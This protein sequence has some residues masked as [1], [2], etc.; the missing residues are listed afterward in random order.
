MT[1]RLAALAVA[2]CFHWATQPAI[3]DPAVASTYR[4]FATVEEGERVVA[5]TPIRDNAPPL[6]ARDVSRKT[7]SWSAGSEAGKPCFDPPIPFVLPPEDPAEPFHKHNHQ[8]SI[9]WLPNGDLL[10]I[11][12]STVSEAGTELTV[13]ASRLRH[14][15]KTWDPSSEF[16]KAPNHNMHGSSIFY[17]GNRTLYHFNGM[18]PEGG[19]GWTHLALLMRYSEDWGVTWT[20]PM[21]IG[22]AFKG[23]QQVISG[24]IATRRGVLIQPCDAGTGG[25]GGTALHLSADSGKTW[26]EPGADKPAVQFTMDG[27]GEGTI[28]GIHAGVVELEDGRLMALGRGD[29]IEGR[30]PISL[31][32][33][34]GSTWVYRAS[35]FAPIGMGQR[36]VLRRLQEGPILLVSFTS[37]DRKNPEGNGMPFVGPDGKE[38]IGHGMFAALSFDEGKTWPLRKLLTP[39][40]GKYHGGAWTGAFNATP[41]R[42]EHAGYLAATQSPDG[43]IHLISSRLYYR[44]NLAWL[45]L[46]TPQ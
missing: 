23:R 40:T 3:A 28:A 32:S 6:W 22:P 17:D 26:L 31:S 29:N 44:F 4:H 38:F 9:T 41:V 12:Y 36:L 20:P 24:T 2:T 33:D 39:G 16:F 19:K 7:V 18:G 25:K 43:M 1:S 15:R 14:G 21:A 37:G 42:A 5:M 34:L 30:M 8:P 10:A 11:W 27:I 45:R 13:L 35:P 46:K